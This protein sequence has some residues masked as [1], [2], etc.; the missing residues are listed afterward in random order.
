M[1]MAVNGMV[2]AEFGLKL[3]GCKG[4][5]VVVAVPGFVPF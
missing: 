2:M 3:K 4:V 5:E 1:M